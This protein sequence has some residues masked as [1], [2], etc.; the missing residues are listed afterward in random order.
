LSPSELPYGM[1]RLGVLMAPEPGEPTEVE[2][3]LNPASAVDREGVPW[4]FPRLVAAGNYSRIGRARIVHDEAGDPTGV[5]RDG[6]ALEPDE[7]WERN[8]RGGGV[9]DA[10]I[11]FVAALDLYVLA[12]TAYGPL[13]PRAAL[14]VSDDL[15]DWRRLGPITFAYD[16]ELG[17]DLGLYPNKDVLLFPEPVA[18]PD[19]EP[20]IGVVH[21]PMWDLE[22]VAPGEGEPLPRGLDDPRP[23]IWVSF[24]PLAGVQGDVRRLTHLGQHRVLARPEHPWE[25]L[26]IGGGAPPV[27]V[28]EGWL[29]L[30]HGVSGQLVSSHDPVAQRYVRYSAGGMILDPERID[31]VTHRSTAPL[32][33][34]ETDEERTGV[35][36]NVVFPT[37]IERRDG[38]VFD[39]F[40]GMADARI[41]AARLSPLPRAPGRG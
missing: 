16:P 4:L 37:A 41:G 31:H 3:V 15:R 10:R 11:T 29:L 19:G 26:K 13:G 27:R 28:R 9:E 18:A 12:Y 2:G 32:L 24:V 8:Q 1:R 5:V 30:H 7:V 23:G 39:V 35:V 14:A 17:A 21:R 33:E 22:L 40:Y 6:F 36:G 38:D 34:P 20:S 25:E